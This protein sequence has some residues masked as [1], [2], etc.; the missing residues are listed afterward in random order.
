MTNWTGGMIPLPAMFWIITACTFYSLSDINI[1]I[2]V[3]IFH[4]HQSLS[5][6]SMLAAS[7][8]YIICGIVALIFFISHNNK[9]RWR[10]I[11]SSLPF[12]V[13]WFAGML[14]LFGC[15]GAIGP[16]FGNIIQSSRG[17]ISII[18][19]FFIARAGHH[20]LETTT[21]GNLIIRRIIA[22]ILMLISFIL[23]NL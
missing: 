6:S 23:F 8:N 4:R 9:Q 22:A 16:I 15:F 2:L 12:A 18:I 3:D 10:D 20:H 13:C 11:P 7:L 5:G 14:F 17:I 21:S 19:G 1:K